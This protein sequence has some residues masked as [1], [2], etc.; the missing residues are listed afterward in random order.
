MKK[1]KYL[2]AFEQSRE[3]SRK[4]N[5]STNQ[6][7]ILSDYVFDACLIEEIS[8]LIY[9]DL[10]KYLN[11]R[12]NNPIMIYGS[13]CGNVHLA[14][15]KYIVSKYPS[16]NVELTLGKVAIKNRVIFDFSREKFSSWSNSKPE[17]LLDAHV[18]ITINDVYIIDCTIG[19]Y[20]NTRCDINKDINIKNN[21]FGGI[22]FGKNT[23]LEFMEIKNLNNL[24][25]K[26]FCDLEYTPV[27]IG[28]DLT[29]ILPPHNVI[30]IS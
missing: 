1:E 5:F 21:F 27:I 25:P 30:I 29:R 24:K 20:L 2:I 19:T 8:S 17:G 18:W 22:I 6:N 11:D 15:L 23:E 14:L 16:I 3:F 4:K 12:L 7:K 26:Y 9:Y 10:K 13:D 28:H